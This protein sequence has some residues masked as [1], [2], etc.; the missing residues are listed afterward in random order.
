MRLVVD[1]SIAIEYLLQ[2]PLGQRALT[3][4]ENADLFAPELVDV[5]VLAVLRREVLGQRL[6]PQRAAE[7]VDD[8]CAWPLERIRH[9]ELA[10]VAWG[11][12]HNATAYDAM[13]LAA[14]RVHDATILTADGPLSRLPIAGFTIQNLAQR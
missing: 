9:R 13:Y 7:A 3:Q 5:E 10:A 12:R 11:L 1:A 2:T 4:L 14:A 8:L 6:D